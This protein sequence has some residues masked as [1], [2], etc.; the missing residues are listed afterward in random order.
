VHS[1]TKMNIFYLCVKFGGK[2]SQGE[3]PSVSRQIELDACIKFQ[4][5]VFLYYL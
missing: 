2:K 4:P 3:D 1:G 5:F